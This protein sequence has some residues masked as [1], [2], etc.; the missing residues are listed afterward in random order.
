[1]KRTKC[2]W[3]LHKP[4]NRRDVILI[5]VISIHFMTRY[6]IREVPSYNV[7]S[8]LHDLTH[9]PIQRFGRRFLPYRLTG[10]SKLS[11]LRFHQRFNIENYMVTLRQQ[12]LMLHHF[13][14]KSVKS[15]FCFPQHEKKKNSFLVMRSPST[16]RKDR[17]Q[18]ESSLSNRPCTVSNPCHRPSKCD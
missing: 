17:D 10:V 1:M 3:R 9:F 18:L 5:P 6:C 4:Y 8:L 14:N 11:T 2:K 16:I 7:S 13:F 15:H 12:N